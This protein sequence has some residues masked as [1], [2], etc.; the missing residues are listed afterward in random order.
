M[1]PNPWR[2]SEILDATGGELQ[3]GGA[4]LL[5]ENISI[6]SR[7]IGIH[8]VFIA[9]K[10]D[11]FDGHD[12]IP[13]VIRAGVKGV[14]VEKNK[15]EKTLVNGYAAEDITC[16]AVNDTIKA[17]GDLARFRRTASPVKVVAITGSNGKTTT[18]EMTAA[19][20]NRRFEVLSTTGN[21][22]ND[23]GLP[24]TLFRLNP[25]HQWAV[26]ELGMN[27]PGEI[28]HLAGICLP[29][30]GIIT[31]AGA[32]HLEGMGSIDAVAKGK[33]ELLRKI[34]TRG[35]AV[36]N[37]D[38]SRIFALADQ[39]AARVL[40]F[41]Q[42][43]KAEVRAEKIEARGQGI[44]FDLVLPCERIRVNLKMPGVFMVS[45]ALAA[46]SAG[47]IAGL[48]ATD[49]KLGLESVEPVKGRMNIRKTGA[50]VFLIDDTYNSN[51]YSAAAAIG[52]LKS[53][54]KGNRS[55]LVFGDMLELGAAAV[56]LH[57]DIGEIAFKAGLDKL[58]L[59]GEYADAVARGAV[60][61][62]M[63]PSDIF[64]GTKEDLLHEMKNWIKPG[65]WI[66]IKGSRSTH[67]E[68]IVESLLSTGLTVRE[69]D[70]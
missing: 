52:A 37:A 10:G 54:A 6:D 53:L 36:L 56:D 15:A 55:A 20:L 24:L 51:P 12:F 58:Y 1:T 44:D 70:H 30:I 62:G 13:Q 46:A 40:F 4:G 33:G 38:D 47:H 25:G 11:R 16:V 34:N 21:L 22:N 64:I 9:I 50:G 61:A 31:N 67:M 39:I 23:I 7:K 43:P 35:S 18:K 32:S 48:S 3:Q 45:N 41:G 27:H 42:S 60:A 8:D 5:F 68:T 66:L 49:I 69:Q 63:A 14:I 59:S 19:V 29:D 17:L 65:D 28:L 2:I 57:T 26:L